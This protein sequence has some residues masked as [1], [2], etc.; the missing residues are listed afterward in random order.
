MLKLHM[1]SC[2]YCNKSEKE[3]K[4][5]SREH[6][7]PQMFGSYKNNPTL[8]GL[9]CDHSNTKVFNPLESRYKEDTEEGIYYQMFDFDDSSQVR[10][11]GENIKTTFSSDLGDAFFN[12]WFP[13]YRFRDGEWKISLLPQIKI[14]RSAGYIVLQVGKLEKIDKKSGKFAKLKKQFIGVESKDVS[15]FAG[16]NAPG[17]ETLLEEAILLVKELGIDYKP[18]KSKF[19]SMPDKGSPAVFEVNMD[20][21][22]GNDV[23]RVIS[24]IAFNY[25]AY[26]AIGSG[27]EDITRHSNFDTLK[28]Y[29]LGELDIPIK[30]VIINLTDEPLLEEDRN[31][32]SRLLGHIITFEKNGK[33]ILAKVSFLNR[34]TYTVAL[35]PIWE[36]IAECDNFGSGHLFDP[37]KHEIH[38]LTRDPAKQG[39]GLAL[40]YGLFNRV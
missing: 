22:L 33:N 7:M 2:I 25:F 32:T 29:I 23:G 40:S 15:I 3:I 11:R 27:R 17:D 39:I 12:E 18:G 9:V 37:L 21:T 14:K 26:C 35:G 13:F 24:K 20:C 36:E 16:S 4:I 19:A 6:V 8:V 5:T 28:Q 1:K 34:R 30:K 38:G 31:T 10:I